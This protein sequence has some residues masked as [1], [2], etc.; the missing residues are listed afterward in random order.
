MTETTDALHLALWIDGKRVQAMDFDPTG[1]A[2]FNPDRQDFSA[3]T[4]E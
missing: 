4:V 2:A 1:Q 3:R